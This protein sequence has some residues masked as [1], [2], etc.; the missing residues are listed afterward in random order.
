MI[1]IPYG[2]SDFSNMPLEQYYYVDRTNYIEKLEERGEKAIHF[3]RPR[4]FGKSL[5]ISTLH[6][7]YGLEFKN[8]FDALF[9]KYYIGKNPTPKANTYLVLSLDFSSIDTKDAKNTYRDFTDNVRT[10]ILSF[11]ATYPT[12]FDQEDLAVIEN[13]ASPQGMLKR[14]WAIMRQKASDQKVYVLVDEYDHFTNELLSADFSSFKKIVSGNGWVRKFYEALKRGNGS[15]IVDRIFLTGVSPVTLDSLTSGYNISSNLSIDLDFCGLMGFTENEVMETLEGVGVPNAHLEKV[16]A[17]LRLWYDG[18]LFHKDTNHKIYNPDMV[19]YF[20]NHYSRYQAYPDDLLDENIASDYGKMDKLFYLNNARKANLALL[21]TILEEG[22][23]TATLTKKYSFEVPWTDDNFIS[24]LYY[25]GVLTIKG[26]DGLD[27]LVFRMPNFVIRQLYFKFFNQL[28]LQETQ[29]S[30]NVVDVEGKVRALA[31]KNDWQPL[32]QLT[33]SILAKLGRED[34]AHF[35]EVSLKTLFTSFFYQVTYYNIF[36]ELEVGKSDKQKGRVDLLLTRR[37][38]FEPT[39]QFVF[40]LKYIKDKQQTQFETTKRQAV[41]Q[42]TAY[43][44]NDDTLKN[45]TDLKAYVV[46]FVG[47]EGKVFDVI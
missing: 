18:Y 47:N 38:P 26:S 11:L 19:L 3:V 22:E 27:G 25:L 41:E 9:G 10:G 37:P 14:L 36:S 28:L 39:F 29:L 16:L 1:K 32:L 12:F 43:I 45:L 34:K 4:R 42:L 46:I 15:G 13:I 21:Q 24:L 6:H 40:E 23:I 5:F 20:A 33:E 7:Y 35:N 17:D 2:I 8:Q 30:P 44:Q 31:Q